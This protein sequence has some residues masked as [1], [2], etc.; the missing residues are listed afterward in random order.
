MRK[1]AISRRK[2]GFVFVAL[3]LAVVLV[4][5][6][7]LAGQYVVYGTIYLD[8]RPLGLYQRVP[9]RTRLQPGASLDGTRYAIHVGAMGFRAPNPDLSVTD[10]VTRV[11]C[12]GG[13]TTFDTY[14]P[15]DASAW[16]ARLPALL[17]P[18]FGRT[19]VVNAGVPG[20]VLAA[21]MEDFNEWA[22]RV[23]PRYVVIHQGPN[24]L[25]RVT[26]SP[27]P[28]SAFARLLDLLP[29]V[30]VLERARPSLAPARLVAS[31]RQ[32]TDDQLRGLRDSLVGALTAVE[33][34][35]ARP[36]LA[37]HALRA[38]AGDVGEVARERVAEAAGLLDL[39]PVASIF[40]FE[41]YNAMIAALAAERHL[42]FADVRAAVGPDPANWGDA[43]HFRAPGSAL[44]AEAIAAAIRKD[45]GG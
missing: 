31:P 38:T 19:E 14:A 35:G 11:W 40:A 20:H 23:R 28:P 7:A 29:A 6:A 10:P 34:A 1:R 4:N 36:V 25:R 42:P 3:A 22:Q 27:R 5:L 21:N 45:A 43:T 8:G 18:S 12:L 37:T 30:T 33:R 16:P 9:G 17:E 26:A 13:S 15:D 24:E 2:I 41:K 32:L 44:A 39:S